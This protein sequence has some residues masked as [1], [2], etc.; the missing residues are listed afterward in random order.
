M[1]DLKNV[2]VALIVLGASLVFS[3]YTRVGWWSLSGLSILLAEIGSNISNER[4]R[5]VLMGLFLM[6]GFLFLILGI[7][8]MNW[9]F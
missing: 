3:Y 9:I 5:K 2:P 1:P 8:K 7:V 6:F 4:D